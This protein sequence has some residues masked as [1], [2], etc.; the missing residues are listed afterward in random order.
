MVLD[1]PTRDGDAELHILTNLPVRAA[2]AGV[3]AELYRR[4]WTI[5]TAFQEMEK[6]LNGEIKALGYPKAALF[7]LCVAPMSYNVMS[8]VKA[9]AAAA[10]G[11]EAA[12]KVSG[13]YL[14]DEVRMSR[15]GMMRAIP[16]DEWVE[17]HDMAPEALGEILLGWARR[18]PWRNTPRA[19]E[20]R[21]SRSRRSKVERRL[22]MWR[23]R[24]S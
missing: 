12:E 10:H 23:H 16:K 13:F 24:R 9:G 3:V 20:A 5:E 17:F 19:R 1:K 22:S 2:R 14:A 18:C 15:R 4:R 11:V 8:T 7:S 21:R 6:T